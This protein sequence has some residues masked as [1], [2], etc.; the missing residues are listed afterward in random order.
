MP[1][2]IESFKLVCAG[3]LN[4]NENH[5]DLSDN[6]PGSATRLVNYEPSLF[7]GYRRIEGF[8]EYN[9]DYPAVDDVNNAGSAQGKVLG[10]AIF[11]DDVTE[12]TKILAARA[13]ANFV[14]TATAG[15]TAFSGSDDNSRSMVL[16]N[17]SNI[18]VT[19]NGTK[20]TVT[21]NYTV[22]GNTVTLTS[23]AS[24][25]DE[26]VINP[27]EYSFYHYTPLIGWRPYTLDHSVTRKM[28]SGSLTVSK[29]RH[30]QF[31]FGDG[32]KVAFVD[33]VNPA[34]IFNGSHWEQLTSSGAGTAPTDSGHTSETGGGDQCLN[35]PALVD[36]FENHLFLAGHQATLATIAHSAPNDAYDFTV[37]N[38]AGQLF[39]GFDAVQIKPFR[40]NLFVFGENGIRKIVPDVT[41]GFV[42]EQVTA[43]V[44]CVARDSVLEIGGDLMFLA[45]DGFRPVAGTSRIGDVE[46]ETVSKPI[47][48]TL[49]DL[50]KNNDMNLLSGV[51]IRSKS[52]IRYFIGDDTND[53]GDSLGIIGGLSQSTGSIKWEFG[54]LLG[55][56]A[57]CCTSEYVDNE[58]LVLHGDYDGKVY[59]QERGK[60]FNDADIVAIYA[61]PY[62]DFGDT[63]IR[64]LVRKVNTFIR[65]EGPLEM[66]LALAFDWGDYNTARP[67]TYSQESEGGPTVYAGRNI[68]YNASNVIY[69]GSSK[70]IMTSDVQGSGFSI[71]ATYVT[72]GKFDPYSIQGIVFEFTQA[73]R[74]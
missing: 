71:R 5:L 12:T 32:N 55:I 42:S 54:E 8:E 58:E 39:A 6:S 60:D 56:R 44:G 30:V 31:N 46:L 36:V 1:D 49:V 19:K 62:L 4:S 33:G 48:A 14:Y 61:T 67:S 74:R 10:L 9:S 50:I 13:D 22:S 45:P 38:G 35:A 41:S 65:A 24:V 15:Q 70:P 37:A 40:D 18:T 66:N 73:G 28:V 34:I 43:N 21:T 68:T 52:Q 29:L 53:V 11:R 17:G 64:K 20:L 16:N 27:Q 57:S 51:V 3:G 2:R 69:G 63:D 72:F 26:I 7:G 25:G 23:A 47:Q 59:R